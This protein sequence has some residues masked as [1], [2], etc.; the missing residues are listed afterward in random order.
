MSDTNH[1]VKQCYTPEEPRPLMVHLFKLKLHIYLFW[2]NKDTTVSQMKTL[3][4]FY[5]VIYWTQKVL[6]DFIFLCSL[7]CVPYKCSSASKVH[8][9]LYKKKIL[10]AE[11]A[12]TLAPGWRQSVTK[13]MPF[14]N[15]LVHSYTCWWQACIT[16]L[17]FHSSMN[18]DGFHPFTT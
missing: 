11:S 8:G 9:N 1:P 7:R 14:M 10:L 16:I 5:L 12:A 3:N 15:F 13:L 18:L 4:I 6:N 2:Y 17:N